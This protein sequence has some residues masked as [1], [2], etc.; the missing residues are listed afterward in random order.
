MTTKTDILII[1][2]CP[3]FYKINLY[4][5]IA[6]HRD[7]FVIFLGI[8][9][10]V[11]M[12]DQYSEKIKFPYVLLNNFQVED[13]SFL[14]TF[15]NVFRLVAKR[16]PR[17]IIY[18]GYIEPELLALSILSSKSKNVLQSESAAE[19][20]NSGWKYWAKTVLFSRYSKAIVSGKVHAEMLHIAKFK[21]EIS[22]SKGVGFMD[23]R[24]ER[25]VVKS[26][27]KQLRFLYVGRLI[28][29]K[30]LK[31][32]I[33]F[34]NTSGHLLT[35]VGDGPLGNQLRAQ[36][37]E[38]INFLGFVRNTEI[39]KVYGEHDVFVLPSLSEPW[40]LVAEE[41][42]YF[43]LPLVLSNKVGSVEELLNENKTGVSFDPTSLPSLSA[44]VEE[45]SQRYDYY[46]ENARNFDMDAKDD[47]QLQA[48][49]KL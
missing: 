47:C 39:G 42:L 16:K 31:R 20:T 10:E 9:K 19:T 5:E 14:K 25:K 21:G 37:K 12:G 22:I 18:G 40:G 46:S 33:A 6:R 3:A 23:K 17:K 49:L 8:S 28:E 13:R 29:L 15:I 1:N 11:V 27:N 35:I 24:Q 36:S 44:A 4:N 2:N 43:G 48:Y 34:F 41:A 30:N 7:I 26:R 32:L 38:N 45:I